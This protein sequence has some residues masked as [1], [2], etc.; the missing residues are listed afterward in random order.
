MQYSVLLAALEEKVTWGFWVGYSIYRERSIKGRTV[1]FREVQRFRQAWVWVLLLLV[2]LALTVPVMGG[3]L[4]PLVSLVMVIAG[5]GLIWLFFVMRL[6]TEVHPDGIY[7]GFF[8][9]SSQKIMYTTIVDHRV[10]EYRP[11]R[12]YGGWGIRFNRSGRAYTVSGNL[13][14]Q[15]ELSNGKGL[16]IGTKDPNEL[17]RAIS[18]AVSE[19]AKEMDRNQ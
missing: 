3:M 7:L 1:I 15:L 4:G 11:I 14:V 2:L 8:P 12:E 17:L 13:G 16:L 9:F 5:A 19:R 6:V 10:R 18:S